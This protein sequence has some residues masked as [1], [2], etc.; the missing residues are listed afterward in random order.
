METI[1]RLCP[2]A[3]L[4]VQHHSINFDIVQH[5]VRFRPVQ[6]A[7]KALQCMHHWQFWYR[8]WPYGRSSD[9]RLPSKKADKTVALRPS[10][11]VASGRPWQVVAASLQIYCRSKL[12]NIAKNQQQAREQGKKLEP[13]YMGWRRCWRFLFNW[14]FTCYCTKHELMVIH[15]L[16]QNSDKHLQL[17]HDGAAFSN[18]LSQELSESGHLTDR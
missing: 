7:A 3:A 18:S 13:C 6:I 2:V 4:N 5:E 8:T 1:C 14:C 10:D 16:F 12:T 17:I 9:F 15:S 11:K